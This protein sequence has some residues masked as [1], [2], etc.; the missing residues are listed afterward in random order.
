MKIMLF[1][2][3]LIFSSIN[4]LSQS[5][6]VNVD[7]LKGQYTGGCKKG[8]AEG[9]GTATG[10]DSYSGDFKNGYPD[11]EGKYTWRNGSWYEGNWKKGVFD[12]NGTFSKVDENKPDSAILLTGF[13]IK[14]NY[15]GKNRKP[16]SVKELTNGISQANI[17]KMRSTGAEITIVV[18][19]ITAGGSSISS[20][21]LPKPMLIEITPFE[22]RFQ[23]RIDNE[24]S[25]PV[26][27]SYI[28]RGV[29][30]PYH[31][32]LSFKTQ[33]QS[34]HEEKVE[35]EIAETAD[36]FIEINIDN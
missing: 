13:W 16:F 3:M 24:N 8:I 1:F 32:I 23:Q 19:S 11:G 30:F 9:T 34:L 17:R 29:T 25:S 18:K 36:W 27:N 31:C 21:I 5:C 4:L 6:T 28:L 33:A 15:I 12:G 7:S 22:G 14:G 10:T 20:P 35:I 2:F 26:T